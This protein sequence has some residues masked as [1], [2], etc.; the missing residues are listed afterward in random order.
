MYREIH[1]IS[2]DPEM[3]KMH[4]WTTEDEV[5]GVSEYETVHYNEFGRRVKIKRDESFSFTKNE[6]QKLLAMVQ[7]DEME[8]T[9]NA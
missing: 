1:E 6:L 2:D 9:G 3:Y 4:V 5:K 8:E 7:A